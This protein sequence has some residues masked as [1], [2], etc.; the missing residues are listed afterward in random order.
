MTNPWRFLLATLLAIAAA[1]T[2]LTQSKEK[3]IQPTASTTPNNYE[4]FVPT[5][6]PTLTIPDQ[7]I[8]TSKIDF[9]EA[10]P[11][12]SGNGAIISQDMLTQ[13]EENK[14]YLEIIYLANLIEGYP[15]PATEQINQTDKAAFEKYLR[16]NIESSQYSYLLERMYQDYGIEHYLDNYLVKHFG[17]Y[18]QITKTNEKI[19]CLGWFAIVSDLIVSHYEKDKLAGV[20]HYNILFPNEIFRIKNKGDITIFYP[21]AF[22]DLQPGDVYIYEHHIGIILNIFTY[23]GKNYYLITEANSPKGSVEFY[24]PTGE[25]IVYLADQTKFLQAVGFR[26]LYILRPTSRANRTITNG[27]PSSD[28]QNIIVNINGG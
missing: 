16:E 28:F 25:P 1:T 14:Q 19:Q 27:V 12:L 24:K 4:F 6:T 26:N 23:D 9:K 10:Y 8:S 2:Y 11:H 20:N 22:E 13:T 17:L 3:N 18:N 7:S 15:N 5:V 21:E